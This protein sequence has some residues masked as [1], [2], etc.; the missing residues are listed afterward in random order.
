M[1]LHELIEDFKAEFT[2]EKHWKSR[3][4][5]D[6]IYHKERVPAWN[7]NPAWDGLLIERC[8]KLEAA[9]FEVTQFYRK[10]AIRMKK[11]KGLSRAEIVQRIVDAVGEDW[12]SISFKRGIY[13]QWRANKV[14]MR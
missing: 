14:W 2:V 1:A 5:V 13:V 9:G 12:N 7:W 11:P 8:E 10:M 3:G 6:G 4:Y